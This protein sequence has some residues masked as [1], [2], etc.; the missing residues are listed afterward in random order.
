MDGDVITG[1]DGMIYGLFASG[2]S[3]KWALDLNLGYGWQGF[4]GVAETEPEPGDELGLNLAFARQIP[5]GSSGNVSLA[6]V[7]EITWT[8]SAADNTHGVERPDSGETVFSLA[9]G[10]KYTVGDVII[11]GLVRIPVTQDQ[12]GM[13]LEAGA[14]YLLGVR[15]MF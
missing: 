3:G 2:R 9:P 6:P 10:L 1:P 14:M 11:E 13:Q 12:Q 7:L 15:R 4:A 5:L 8:D